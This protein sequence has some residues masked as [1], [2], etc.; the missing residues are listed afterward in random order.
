MCSLVSFVGRPSRTKK[1]ASRY[2][3]GVAHCQWP[4]FCTS[5]STLPARPSTRTTRRRE[6]HHLR[7]PPPRPHRTRAHARYAHSAQ[8]FLVLSHLLMQWP[9]K[10]W[11]ARRA[12][13]AIGTRHRRQRRHAVKRTRIARRARRAQQRGRYQRDVGNPART[14]GT[15]TRGARHVLHVP[16]TTLQSSAAAASAFSWHSGPAPTRAH[17]RDEIGRRDRGN[18]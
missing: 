10:T 4:I 6:R 18:A 1:N 3:R 16:H 8:L 17:A 2:I 7:S 14:R 13:E 15:T 9:W 12:V 11:S 5:Q